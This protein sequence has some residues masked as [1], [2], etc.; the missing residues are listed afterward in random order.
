[1]PGTK[2]TKPLEEST[3]IMS[4]LIK[5]SDCAEELWGEKLSSIAVA[6]TEFIQRRAESGERRIVF[7]TGLLK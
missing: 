6:K 4:A 7:M 1:M 2:Y 5:E 3:S